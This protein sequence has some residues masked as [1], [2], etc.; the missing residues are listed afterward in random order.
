MVWDGLPHLF[1]EVTPTAVNTG[2]KQLVAV[3][4]APD[5]VGA[6]NTVEIGGEQFVTGPTPM[7]VDLAGD[8]SGE[9]LMPIIETPEPREEGSSTGPVA[10]GPRTDLLRPTRAKMKPNYLEDF[11][12]D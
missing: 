4:K 2:G 12:T 9:E 3:N 7:E 8:T 10:E 6:D 5:P 1:Q 11:V